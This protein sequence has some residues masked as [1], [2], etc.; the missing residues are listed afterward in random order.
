MKLAQTQ[1]Y[2]L[3]LLLLSIPLAN[4]KLI[5]GE[6]YGESLQL[7]R[8]EALSSLA[9]SIFVQIESSSEVYQNDKGESYFNS[10]THSST[11]LPMIGVE[12][13]CYAALKQQYCSAKMD[14]TKSLANYQQQIKS[15]Q[16]SINTQ[17][18][19][20]AKLP[21]EQH[22]DQ[23]AELLSQYEQYEKYLTVITFMS[24]QNNVDF[25]P[26]I[27]K[28]ELRRK[29]ISLEKR[30]NSLQLAARLL[31]KGI[32]QNRIYVRPATLEN[33]R[34]ITPFANA[35]LSQ[36]QS[37]VQTVSNPDQA[38]YFFSGSYQI[39]DQGIQVTYSLTDKQGNTLKTR[40]IELTPA[41]YQHYRTDPVALDFDALLH[42]GYAISSDF[43]V[44]LSTN[45]GS[46]QLLFNGGDTIELL[47]KVNQPGYFYIVGHSKNEQQEL[48]YLLDINEVQGNRRFVYYVNADDANKWISLGEF[49]AS[50]P[51]GVES[52][53]VIASN[54]DVVDAL[55]SYVYDPS[56]GYYILARDV[57]QGVIR[58]RGQRGL[59]KVM[60]KNSNKEAET[61]EAVLMFTTQK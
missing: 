28:Q 38:K 39:H 27:T 23:L 43:K 55:P 13:D 53:Q 4:A 52:I 58:T 44:Q 20:M 16:Q 7:A 18:E 60:K 8:E 46:R 10:T 11:D 12:F 47:I 31:S 32:N 21:I 59:K 29:L 9:S 33:S 57:K 3:L 49:E 5:T 34:E 30:V 22:Y 35:L 50:E 1:L 17:L 37:L 36:L 40:L 26:A 41:S 48:S 56:N 15:I 61:A 54:D 14:T 19:N 42:K 2:A 25:S 24:G 51:Y 6:G 45:K